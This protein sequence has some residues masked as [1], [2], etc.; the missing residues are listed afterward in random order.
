MSILTEVV[1]YIKNIKEAVF[2]IKM[3][4]RELL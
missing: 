3:L 2:N 4:L 1:S